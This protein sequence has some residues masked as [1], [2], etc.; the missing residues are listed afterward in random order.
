MKRKRIGVLAG[1]WSSEREISLLS[2]RNVY[3]SLKRQ[4]FDAIFIDVNHNFMERL[5]QERIDV[6]FVILHGKPGEDGT[7]QGVLELLSIPYTGSGV[8]A[9][10]I[11]MDKFTT[12]RLFEA[13]KIPTPSYIFIPKDSSLEDKLKEA[14]KRFGFP[15]VLKPRA[16]GSSV[17]VK[18]IKDPTSL[19]RECKQAKERFGDLILEKYIKGMMATVGILNERA[20]PILE[21]VPKHQEFYDYKAKYT[22]GET[23]FII[24]AGLERDVYEKTQS[25]AL[26]AHKVIGC[27]GFSRV[28]LIVEDNKRPYLLEVN[29]IPG[30]TELSD[31][32]AEASYEGMSYD[33]L[34]LEI[35]KSAFTRPG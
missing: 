33:E 18:I 7:I 9:S 30:M 11:S 4:G 25:L 23:E 14:E 35:L 16:Q 1:G 8:E 5:K 31:L 22:K 20:L 17:G 13:H 10:A 28:D 27:W 21:I 32:P 6:A 19:K 3:N 29:S 15:M 26:A 34:I 12:K 2:G 24:P